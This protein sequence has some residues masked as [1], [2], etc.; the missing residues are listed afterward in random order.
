MP[1]VSATTTA[2]LCWVLLSKEQTEKRNV[3]CFW[4][5]TC[6]KYL[7]L[8]SAAVLLFRVLPVL[9]FFICLLIVSRFS[10]FLRNCWTNI[11]LYLFLAVS[12]WPSLRLLLYRF[13]GGLV[14]VGV[15]WTGLGWSGDPKI[16]NELLQ[17]RLFHA[18]KNA[19]SFYYFFHILCTSWRKAY[20][21]AT[22]LL[23]LA[24]CSFNR[25]FNNYCST[26]RH[27]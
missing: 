16:M 9:H 24:R 19:Q 11:L 5:Y 22:T 3:A 7:A 17:M 6:R 26:M 10:L 14:A 21:A 13:R 23:H 2:I 15:G 27:S 1:L 8:L 25:Q 4:C 12:W 20:N 18:V